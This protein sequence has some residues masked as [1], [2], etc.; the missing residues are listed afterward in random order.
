[1]QGRWPYER[2]KPIVGGRVSPSPVSHWHKKAGQHEHRLVKAYAATL[3]GG[4]TGGVIT[5]G[6][7]TSVTV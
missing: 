4:G 5:R 3:R 7:A 1:M 2:R 6:T